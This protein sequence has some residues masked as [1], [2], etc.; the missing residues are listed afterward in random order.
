MPSAVARKPEGNLV[1]MTSSLPRARSPRRRSD[2]PPLYIAAVSNKVT[3]P[4]RLA[5]SAAGFFLATVRAAIGELGGMEAGKAARIAPSHRASAEPG[6]LQLAVAKA[7]SDVII[8]PSS[9][10]SQPSRSIIPVPSAPHSRSQSGR[11][12]SIHA[13]GRDVSEVKHVLPTE[14]FP[15]PGRHY[16]LGLRIVATDEQRVIAVVDERAG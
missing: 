1:A 10:T 12:I 15:Q 8:A 11:Y 3:P 5:S 4:A 16:R 13:R 6:Y 9:L 7:R 2:A 14:P